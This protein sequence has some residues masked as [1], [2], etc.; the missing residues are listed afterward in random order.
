[1]ASDSERRPEVVREGVEGEM[2]MGWGGSFSDR[3]L[4]YLSTSD[5]LGSLHEVGGC[6]SCMIL[7]LEN[8]FVHVHMRGSKHTHMHTHT[9]T[10]TCT[11]TH[12]HRH[13]RHN[14]HTLIHT[15]CHV[16]TTAT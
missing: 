10:H 8:C 2:V 16:R 3:M 7:S 4:M 12:T 13:T 15:Q 11:H 6:Y 5:E 1:M 14:M 9:H